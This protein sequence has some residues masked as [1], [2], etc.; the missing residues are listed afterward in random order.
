MPFLAAFLGPIF[1]WLF[2]FFAGYFGKKAL[3]YVSL[4]TIF[5]GLTAGFYLAVKLLVVG[6]M[7]QVTD[8]VFLMVFWSVWPSNAETCMTSIFAVEVAAFIYRYQVRLLVM[9]AGL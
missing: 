3:V 9:M 7:T 2:G 1:R 6:V 5:L 4:G 8:P